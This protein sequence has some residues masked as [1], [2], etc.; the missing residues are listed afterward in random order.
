[1]HGRR[2][3]GA[4]RRGPG[5]RRVP[6]RARG[7][8]LVEMMMTVFLAALLLLLGVPAFNDAML[9]AKL[10]TFANDLYA[11]IQLARGEAIK[12]NVQVTVCAS[13][14]GLT[15]AA[16]GDWEQ[17]WIVTDG[18][19][20]LQKQEALP[21]HFKVVEGSGTLS[22]VFEPIGVGATTA[23]FTICRNDPVGPQKRMLSVT[24]TGSTYVTR[25]SATTCP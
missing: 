24:G 19:S 3:R 9:G 8:T 10:G 20:V 16:S 14:D 21:A 4:G 15:C 22:L 12:R 13:D 11:S 23:S 17:G 5:G 2:Q 25:D 6:A 1:M 18:T 7:F